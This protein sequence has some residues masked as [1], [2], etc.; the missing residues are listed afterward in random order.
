MLFALYKIRRD[1]KGKTEMVFSGKRLK[2]FKSFKKMPDGSL[3]YHEEVKHPGASLVLPFVKDKIVLIRQYRGVIGRNIWEFPAGVLEPDETPLS[4]ARREV[5]EETGYEVSKI[6]KIGKIY[7]S[8]GFTDEVIHIFR[9]ECGK[10]A[11]S[12]LEED[13]FISIKLV[14][15]KELIAMFLSGKI[16]DSKSI[17]AM[18][19]SGII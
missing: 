17:A 2:V 5:L 8:P 12:R 13:E 14:T 15:R 18:A 9:A 1:M 7:T 4:C 6:K 10:K 3:A 16:N 19:F 11:G